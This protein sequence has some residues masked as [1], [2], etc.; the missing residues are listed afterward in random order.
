ML[1]N[2]EP[3]CDDV[4]GLALG[5]VGAVLE[6]SDTFFATAFTLFLELD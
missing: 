1:I 5:T 3:V 2:N 4:G 6:F